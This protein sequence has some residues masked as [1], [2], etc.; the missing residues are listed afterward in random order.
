MGAADQQHDEDAALVERAAAGDTDAFGQLYA[1]HRERVY[2]LAYRYVHNQQ[3]A[4]DLCQEVFVRA[5]EALG[6]FRGDARFSTWLLRIATNTC[7][8]HLRHSRVRQHGELD[9]QWVTDDARLPGQRTAPDPSRGLRRDEIAQAIEG[10]LA[11]LSED[12]R[13]VFVLH[14][15][16]GLTYHEIAETVG[17]PVGTVMSRLHYARQRL[18]GLLAWWERE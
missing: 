13:T 1:A 11:Q 3:D 17:I 8:D 5:F 9:E 14:E 2:R 16:E 7:I 12:H 15:M 10:A 6:G 4:L 18:R